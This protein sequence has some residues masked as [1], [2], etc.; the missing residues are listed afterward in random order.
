MCPS[1]DVSR[2]GFRGLTVSS[3]SQ[4]RATSAGPGAQGPRTGGSAQDKAG[5]LAEGERGREVFS[6]PHISVLSPWP[7]EVP[8]RPG[9]AGFL[10]LRSLLHAKT[11]VQAEDPA[12]SVA[13]G[14]G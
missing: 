7:P 1:Q 11:L 4:A 8:S 6:F 2:G 3:K 5:V 12:A 14:L 10:L 13:V 9:E